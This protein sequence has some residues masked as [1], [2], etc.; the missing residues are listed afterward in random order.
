MSTVDERYD[1]KRGSPAAVVAIA[2][3]CRPAAI[4]VLGSQEELKT[5]VA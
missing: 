3:E 2:I 4:G 1:R 5:T